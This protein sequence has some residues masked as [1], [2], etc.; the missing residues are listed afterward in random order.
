MHVRLFL[1]GSLALCCAIGASLDLSAGQRGRDRRAARRGVAAAY[2]QRR[3]SR[4]AQRRGFAPQQ[5][6]TPQSHYY[7][8]Y[9]TEDIRPTW[10]RA[11]VAPA[12]VPDP[13]FEAVAPPPEIPP[14]E[15]TQAEESTVPD[16]DPWYPDP[17]A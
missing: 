16:L 15:E 5:N 12:P 17:P 4:R 11:T 14:P 8:P 3:I 2:Q 10:E 13:L 9:G 7:N 1:V 6:S